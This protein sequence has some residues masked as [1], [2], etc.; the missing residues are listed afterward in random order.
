MR[1]EREGKDGVQ[2][3]NRK[4]LESDGGTKGRRPASTRHRRVGPADGGSG[5]PQ[6][7]P[8]RGSRFLH[9]HGVSPSSSLSRHPTVTLFHGSVNF[10]RTA[11]SARYHS[12]GM[13]GPAWT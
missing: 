13:K 4:L 6:D 2:L 11:F 12:T 9:P 7:V 1:G 8:A 3:L 5:T 10:D